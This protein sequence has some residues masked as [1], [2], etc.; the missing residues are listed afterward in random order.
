MDF[1]VN[2][3]TYF[4]SLAEDERR[5]LLFV[6][7]EA[8]TRPLAVYE[9][10]PDSKSFAVVLKQKDPDSEREPVHPILNCAPGALAHLQYVGCTFSKE[11]PH[12]CVLQEP[13]LSLPKGWAAMLPIY[14]SFTAPHL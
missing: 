4:L 13:A 10:A 12:P 14:L 1:Q 3:K 7:G 11:V 5:W 6:E 8:G 9:D 2:G